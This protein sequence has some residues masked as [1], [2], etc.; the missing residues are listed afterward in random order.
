M[1]RRRPEPRGAGFTNGSQAG[2]ARADHDAAALLAAH[3]LVLGGVADPGEVDVAEL[4][5]ATAASTVAQ[6]GGGHAAAAG[7]DLLVERDEVLTDAG[8]DVG[9]PGADLLGLRIELRDG[10]VSLGLEGLQARD[11]LGT[12][13]LELGDAGRQGLGALHD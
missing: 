5:A 2:L 7:P 12:A 4:E 3:H 11:E 8:D 10:G 9:S 13:G 1:T 6:L